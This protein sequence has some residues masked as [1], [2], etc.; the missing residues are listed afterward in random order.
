MRML[1]RLPYQLLLELVESDVLHS[2]YLM[3]LVSSNDHSAPG[4][5]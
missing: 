2:Q 5:V 1:N 3:Q 4:S